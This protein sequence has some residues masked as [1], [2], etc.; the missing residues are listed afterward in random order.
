MGA[1]LLTNGKDPKAEY[2]PSDISRKSIGTPTTIS[3]NVYGIRKDPV[4]ER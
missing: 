1:I 3:I 2:W 4:G